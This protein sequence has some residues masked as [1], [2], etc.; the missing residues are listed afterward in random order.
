MFALQLHSGIIRPQL[1]G[2]VTETHRAAPLVALSG[3]IWTEEQVSDGEQQGF[4]Q[5]PCF[6]VNAVFVQMLEDRETSFTFMV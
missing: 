5:R 2:G 6:I 4:S 1:N 3:E